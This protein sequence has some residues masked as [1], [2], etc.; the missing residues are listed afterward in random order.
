MLSKSVSKLVQITFRPHRLRHTHS[1]FR[2]KQ[3]QNKDPTL[4]TILGILPQKSDA[5][6]ILIVILSSMNVIVSHKR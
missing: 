3:F 1:H 5:S 6:V 2:L 4:L